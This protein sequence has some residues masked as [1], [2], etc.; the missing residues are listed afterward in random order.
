MFRNWRRRGR[1][2]RVSERNARR[3]AEIA[4]SRKQTLFVIVARP[5]GKEPGAP[6]FAL[7][8]LGD[9]AKKPEG[10]E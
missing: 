7:E 9:R 6:Y 5:Q 3:R 4:N 2:Q 1:Y 10:N 8:G